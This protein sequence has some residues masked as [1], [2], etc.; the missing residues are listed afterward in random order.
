MTK[1]S[2]VT[3]GITAA[4][5]AIHWQSSAVVSE[6]LPDAFWLDV[7]YGVISPEFSRMLQ[8]HSFLIGLL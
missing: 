1:Y 8:R 5:G 7:S 4:V 6:R 3:S 2:R